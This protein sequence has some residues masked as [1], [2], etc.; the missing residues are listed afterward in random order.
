MPQYTNA[1][2]PSLVSS[3]T[4]KHLHAINSVPL[5]SLP[6]AVTNSRERLLSLG[7]GKVLHPLHCRPNA[8]GAFW[9]F[10]SAALTH[11][12]GSHYS[13]SPTAPSNGEGKV[14]PQIL[15]S[16]PQLRWHPFLS[17]TWS[18]HC[19]CTSMC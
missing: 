15:Q 6:S 19:V 4:A 18:A 8:Y 11:G 9:F 2:D 14:L 3:I 16:E 13:Q 10:K 7:E 12:Q 17:P 5:P 1:A